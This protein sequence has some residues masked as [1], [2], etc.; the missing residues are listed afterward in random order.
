MGQIHS[1]LDAGWVLRAI[2]EQIT[3]PTACL[4]VSLVIFFSVRRCPE[5]KSLTSRMK[6]NLIVACCGTE[7]LG[8]GQEGTLPWRL[9]KEM[10][11]FAKMTSFRSESA[12][13]KDVWPAVVMGRKTWQSIPE[14]FRPLK[15]RRNAVL[16]RNPYFHSG[17][18]WPGAAE[19]PRAADVLVPASL[20]AALEELHDLSNDSDE[21][22]VWVIGGASVYA[23]ALPSADRVY[24]TH[25]KNK[26]F[27]CD[28][29]F[30][31]TMSE[32]AKDFVRTT[33]P[34]VSGEVQRE[35]DVEYQF[36]VFER[37]ESSPP[38]L[39]H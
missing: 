29:N 11:H 4:V 25:I 20:P 27:K 13:A 39:Y 3:H 5:V 36:L 18:L 38:A 7:V 33:D 8:I 22:V 32:L 10:R 14:K 2:P 6:L 16:T 17:T 28:V 30:P 1:R 19:D 15:G 35:G 34:L 24:L 31:V 9:P 37:K 26:D 23:E 12:I 21:L